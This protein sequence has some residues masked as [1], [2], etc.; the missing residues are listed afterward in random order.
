MSELFTVAQASTLTNIAKPTL[1][2]YTKRYQRYLS[3]EATPEHGAER[4]FTEADLETLAFVFSYTSAGQTHAQAMKALDAGELENFDWHWP[5][6][7]IEPTQSAEAT[8]SALIPIERLQAAQYIA[9]DSQQREAE[10]LAKLEQ[11]QEQIQRLQNDL[12]L[13]NGELAGYKQRQYRAPK[14]W[15]A[16]FGGEP[17]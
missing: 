7:E 4:L 15:R 2:G 12:G 11:A 3:T 16:I 10:A 9:T 6:P 14:W 1:R 8:T 13:A 5:E 17:E